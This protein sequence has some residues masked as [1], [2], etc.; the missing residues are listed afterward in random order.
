MQLQT[1]H[2]EHGKEDLYPLVAETQGRSA[3]PCY[4]DGT[5]D[6]IERI[7]ADR[8]I[9][10]DSL[11]VQQTLLATAASASEPY[12][13]LIENRLGLGRNA[14]SIWQEMVDRH[15]F[16]GAYESVKRFVRKLRG[17]TAPEARAVI[18]TPPG[19]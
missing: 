4:F 15:G 5:Y 10:G 3:P 14:M 11:D 12:R 18:T 7:L 1:E 19:E 9:M 8:A 16:T 17:P 2:D 13:E 6:S